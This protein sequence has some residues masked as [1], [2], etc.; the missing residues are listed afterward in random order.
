MAGFTTC[1]P[2]FTSTSAA[3]QTE[4]SDDK[5]FEKCVE[6][7][8]APGYL[9]FHSAV[10]LQNKAKT[11]HSTPQESIAYKDFSDFYRTATVSIYEHPA[12]SFEP[13]IVYIPPTSATSHTVYHIT[14]GQQWC[15]RHPASPLMRSAQNQYSPSAPG[16]HERAVLDTKTRR[17]R[18]NGAFG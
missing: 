12:Y 11:I 1:Q 7:G 13:I 16:L 9:R 14:V 10:S 15:T 2:W 17:E 5:I 18:D 6:T 4:H 3:A 8:I